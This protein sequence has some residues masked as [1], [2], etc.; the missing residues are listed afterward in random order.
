VNTLRGARGTVTAPPRIQKCSCDGGGWIVTLDRG[1]YQAPATAGML[2]FT[3]WICLDYA[4][5][6]ARPGG[7]GAVQGTVSVTWEVSERIARI[8]VA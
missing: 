5:S 8:V 7:A 6:P 3:R 4:P 1:R 2:R